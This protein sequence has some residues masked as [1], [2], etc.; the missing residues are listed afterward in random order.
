MMR[1]LAD[2]TGAILLRASPAFRTRVSEFAM[3][4]NQLG[5]LF[6]VPVLQSDVL[7][8][9]IQSG[10]LTFILTSAPDDATGIQDSV[11]CPIYPQI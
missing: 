10:S 6:K 3:H 8:I 9:K 2:D 5:N 4:E 7:M 1:I 11:R